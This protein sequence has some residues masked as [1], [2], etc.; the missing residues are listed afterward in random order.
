MNR[1]EVI[2]MNILDWTVKQL[3]RVMKILR[4]LMVMEIFAV[5]LLKQADIVVTN[6]PFSLFRE[7]TAQLIE[8]KKNF[9]TKR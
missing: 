9:L 5:E 4:I 7:Y 1:K 6:P 8:Y 3:I 2:F